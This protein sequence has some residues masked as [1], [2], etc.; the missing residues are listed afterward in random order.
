MRTTGVLTS[1]SR[2][3]GGLFESVRCLHRSLAE[4]PG[5]EVRVLGIEDEFTREDL[6]TWRPTTVEAYPMVGW[7]QFAYS[8]G[9]RRRLLGPDQSDIVHTHGIWEYP[10]IAVTA[11]HRKFRRPYLVSPHGMLDPWAV[12]NSSWKKRLAAVLYERDHL[13]GA[14][15]IHALCKPEV[16]AIRRFGLTNPVCIIPNGVELPPEPEGHP[17]TAEDSPFGPAIGGRKVLLYL[18]RI[19]PKKGLINLLRAWKAHVD[20]NRALANSWA[21]AIAGWD[22]GGHEAELRRMT[23]ECG[24]EDSVHFL[25]PRFGR[26]KD[27]CYRACDAFILPSVSE[28]LPLVVLE[29]WSH[30]KPVLMT[31]E[32]NLPEGFAARAALRIGGDVAGIAEGM[33]DLFALSDGERQGIGESGLALVKERF[34]WSKIAGDMAS[35]YGWLLGNGP[36]PDCVVR[37]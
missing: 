12:R 36:K 11:W 2:R 24:V 1:V 22:R 30:G 21:L 7:R 3:A 15:C 17:S 35:V 10:S 32:C 28:G 6:P 18:G 26:E 16:Q 4:L 29:A 9:L 31:P 19:H 37:E 27:A 14:A 20:A 5:M 33:R 23:M 13:A 34:T 25:G 8:P